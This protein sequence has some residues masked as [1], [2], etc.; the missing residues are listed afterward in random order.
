MKAPEWGWE[1]M[2]SLTK[3]NDMKSGFL[4]NSEL[5]IVAEVETFEAT[6][7]SQVADISDDS[8]WTLLDYY[9]SSEENKEGVT[10]KVKGFHVLDSQVIKSLAMILLL[11]QYFIQK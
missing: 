2:I 3:I 7:T 10:V 6:S 9:S 8:E 11:F 1:D 4:V 5:M